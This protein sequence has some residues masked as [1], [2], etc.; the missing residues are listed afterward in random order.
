MKIKYKKLLPQPA[1][2]DILLF[3][4]N[5]GMKVNFIIALLVVNLILGAI[6]TILLLLK[7]IL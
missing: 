5:R 1:K 2:D 4:A 6:Q 3:L 7:L